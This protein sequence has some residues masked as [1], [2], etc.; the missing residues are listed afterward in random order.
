MDCM[1]L[2]REKL[3][4]TRYRD[5]KRVIEKSRFREIRVSFRYVKF[6]MPMK[7]PSGNSE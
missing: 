4:V 3:G 2:M 5:R 1:L 7:H 6:E